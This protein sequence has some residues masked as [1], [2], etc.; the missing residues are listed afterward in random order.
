MPTLPLQAATHRSLYI[1]GLLYILDTILV[2]WADVY[3]GNLDTSKVVNWLVT[4]Q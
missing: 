1:P 3:V 4:L 2:Y